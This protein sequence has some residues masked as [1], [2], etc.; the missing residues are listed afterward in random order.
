[1]GFTYRSLLCPPSLV[2]FLPSAVL[3][4]RTWGET[5]YTLQLCTPFVVL[6]SL[7]PSLN[8]VLYKQFKLINKERIRSNMEMLLSLAEYKTQNIFQHSQCENLWSPVYCSEKWELVCLH[9][10][11][12]PRTLMR[13]ATGKQVSAFVLSGEL[14]VLRYFQCP[15]EGGQFG[16]FP[17]GVSLTPLRVEQLPGS[18]LPLHC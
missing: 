9:F 6:Q 8:R 4:A 17:H 2:A 13:H 18:I 15:K 16:P 3:P 7:T 11:C 14:S 1:M 12:R 5:E 10:F